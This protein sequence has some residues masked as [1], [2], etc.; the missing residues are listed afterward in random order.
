ME[1]MIQVMMDITNTLISFKLNEEFAYPPEKAIPNYT[2]YIQD[3]IDLGTIRSRL[4]ENYYKSSIDWYNDVCRVYEN[5]IS[6]HRKEFPWASIAAYNLSQFKKLAIGL[7]CHDAGEWHEFVRR[8]LNKV[9]NTASNS[10]VPHCLDPL[11]DTIVKYAETVLPPTPKAI[12]ETVEWLNRWCERDEVRCDL[13]YLLKKL[14]PSLNFGSGEALIIDS[15]KLN[16][17]AL[18]GLSMYVK[19]RMAI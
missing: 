2:D 16:H 3:P 14:Q 19:A 5:G 10:P 11:L 18:K 1:R 15:D 8:K 9:I 4:E 6:F 17:A 13:I 12:V 7:H